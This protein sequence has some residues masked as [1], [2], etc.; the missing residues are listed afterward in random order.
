M[1]TDYQLTGKIYRPL[2][3]YTLGNCSQ[4]MPDVNTWYY[5]ATTRQFK[6]CEGFAAFLSARF[7]GHKFKVSVAK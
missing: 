7:P 6:T 2:N 3:A 1:K 5:F 4:E